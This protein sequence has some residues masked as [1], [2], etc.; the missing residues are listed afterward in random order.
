MRT[1][2]E[3]LEAA[4]PAPVL[5]PIQVDPSPRRRAGPILNRNEEEMARD[6]EVGFL[7]EQFVSHLDSLARSEADS[8][9]GIH[10]ATRYAQAARLYG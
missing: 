8:C 7:G 3:T 6:F 9:P 4:E 1:L 2:R 5:T 10:L